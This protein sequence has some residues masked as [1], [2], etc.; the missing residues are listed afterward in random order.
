MFGSALGLNERSGREGLRR[1]RWGRR[2]C[3]RRMGGLGNGK[4]EERF[5]RWGGVGLYERRR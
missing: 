4:G 1:C 3:N 5:R 2:V